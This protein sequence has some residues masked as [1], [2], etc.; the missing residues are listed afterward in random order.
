MG[1]GTAT[2]GTHYPLGAFG[3]WILSPLLL[4]LGP[5]SRLLILDPPPLDGVCMRSWIFV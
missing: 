4:D 1:R 5:S 2:S 3:A